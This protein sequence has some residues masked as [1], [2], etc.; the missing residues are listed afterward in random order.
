MHTSSPYKGSQQ[1]KMGNGLGASIH[2]VGYTKVHSK[3]NLNSYYT[4][5]NLLLVPSLTHNLL[6]VGQFALDNN[7]YFEFHS[8]LCYVKCQ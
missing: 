7:V 4:V 2:V 8:F 5:T 3:L 1:A 6:S